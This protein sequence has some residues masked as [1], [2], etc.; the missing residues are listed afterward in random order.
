[1]NVAVACRWFGRLD[2]DGDDDLSAAGQIEAVVQHLLE[3]FCIGNDVIG[4]KDGHD[5]GG[6]TRPD[7]GGTQGDGSAGVAT[8]GFGDNV[9]LWNF[10]QLLPHGFGLG[11]IGDN[12][13]VSSGN[14][15]QNAVDCLLEK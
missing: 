2:A 4:R 11:G 7:E 6:G 10:R 14:D 5:A 3:L 1:M 9:F 15:W 8:A 12:D 13:D